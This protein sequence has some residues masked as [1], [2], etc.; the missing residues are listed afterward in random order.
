M[1]LVSFIGRCAT[2][3]EYN[4]SNYGYFTDYT[5]QKQKIEFTKSLRKHFHE[6]DFRNYKKFLIAVNSYGKVDF[7]G[8]P[9]D[10]LLSDYDLNRFLSQNLK[11]NNNNNNK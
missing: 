11:N 5:T 6:S 10:S 8:N 3:D 2:L 9:A 4:V 7:K 1:L